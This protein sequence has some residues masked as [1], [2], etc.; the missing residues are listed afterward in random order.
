M[1]FAT[2]NEEL[3]GEN[4]KQVDDIFFF[5]YQC[6]MT[7]NDITQDTPNYSSDDEDIAT[8]GPA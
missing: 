7:K 4:Q 5:G 8:D 1:G 6:C 3:E 2:Q